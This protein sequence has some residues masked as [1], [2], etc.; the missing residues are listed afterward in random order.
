MFASKYNEGLQPYLG[1]FVTS[2]WNLLTTTGI[3]QKFDLLISNAI[4]FLSCVACKEQSRSFFEAPNVLEGMCK[5]V[6]LP[7]VEFKQ[8][9]EELFEDNPEEY[10]RREGEM[11]KVA[12]GIREEELPPTFQSQVPFKVL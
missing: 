9:D 6:I 7:N 3:A 1:E 5:H 10:I 2:A 12:M 11:L 4:D 8:T